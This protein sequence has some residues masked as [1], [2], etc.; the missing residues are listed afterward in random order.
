MIMYGI[1][2]SKIYINNAKRQNLDLR[3]CHNC[4]KF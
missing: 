4:Y 1:N 2:W 3:T